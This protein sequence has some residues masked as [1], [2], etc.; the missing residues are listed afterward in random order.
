VLGVISLVTKK[1]T[2][3]RKR[4]GTSARFAIGFIELE[5]LEIAGYQ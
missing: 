5:N 4:I 3:M 2:R 1:T